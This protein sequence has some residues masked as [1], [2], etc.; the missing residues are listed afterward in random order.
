MTTEIVSRHGQMAP[1]GQ[2]PGPWVRTIAPDQGLQ[3]ATSL[4]CAHVLFGH[5]VSAD[6]L[7]LFPAFVNQEI[8]LTCAAFRLLLR[9]QKIQTGPPRPAW[10][11]FRVGCVFSTVPSISLSLH[12]STSLIWPMRAF[13]FTTQKP[14]GSGRG[15]PSESSGTY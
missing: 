7:I 4:A 10:Q 13:E 11:P 6:N 1:G 12:S 3:V 2:N 14:V 5:S 8:P 9:N 15:W